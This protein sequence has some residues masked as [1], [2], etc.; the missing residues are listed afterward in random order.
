[1]EKEE[2]L[3]GLNLNLIQDK[4][5]SMIER[6]KITNKPRSGKASYHINDESPSTISEVRDSDD[7]PIINIYDTPILLTKTYESENSKYEQI[8]TEFLDFKKFA[9][10]Q[11]SNIKSSMVYRNEKDNNSSSEKEYLKKE[12]EYLEK[13]NKELR[14]MVSDL[15]KQ[16][17]NSRQ[18]QSTETVQAP[19]KTVNYRKNSKRIINIETSR[20]SPNESLKSTSDN[21]HKINPFRSESSEVNETMGTQRRR[22]MTPN[23]NKQSSN[24]RPQV[25][26]N[27]YPEREKDLRP[28]SIPGNT[29]Y[30]ERV[31]FGKSVMV[32]GDSI[33]KRTR[34][35]G[36]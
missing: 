10:D 5:L 1:M 29:T 22:K 14:E 33:A 36:L 12:N 27:N 3:I 11:I 6:K 8:Y 19:W 21:Q 35:R 31:R 20:E 2:K 13:A 30:A 9:F 7:P 32:F 25:V 28:K 16:N 18:N 24:T 26:V 23:F 15:I 4:T 34:S 17:I